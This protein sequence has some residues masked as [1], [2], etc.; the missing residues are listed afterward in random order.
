MSFISKDGI[1]K[2]FDVLMGTKD[3][4]PETKYNI[5]V[6]ENFI[7]H[8]FESE[9]GLQGISEIKEE[10]EIFTK[11]FSDSFK[12]MI[13]NFF[14]NFSIE[15]GK[16]KN[17]DNTFNNPAIKYTVLINDKEL[18]SDYAFNKKE[19]RDFSTKDGIFGVEFI[20]YSFDKGESGK[21]ELSQ[22][23][24][25][26]NIQIVLNLQ[27]RLNGLKLNGLEFKVG[28]KDLI[29]KNQSHFVKVQEM[30]T[31][32][33][34]LSPFL[35]LKVIGFEDTYYSVLGVSKSGLFLMLY[36][37]LSFCLVMICPFLAFF[38]KY[39]EFW[40]HYDKSNKKIYISEESKGDIAL[41][42]KLFNK[43]VK[44]ISAE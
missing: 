43:I 18:Y 7:S 1:E 8:I 11:D 29:H 20:S 33:S 3:K 36:W 16:A 6:D 5:I 37:Y 22:S 24:D 30:G 27:N 12:I 17:I 38:I 28:T 21:D 13:D 39:R 19:L 2:K 31:D 15:N 35:D 14:S 44:E 4:I 10:R 34:R 23:L 42:R 9:E 26:S 40:V 41:R 25:S 32:V